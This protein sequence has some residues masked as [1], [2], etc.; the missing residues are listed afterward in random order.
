MNYKSDIINGFNKPSWILHPFK[1]LKYN[2]IIKDISIVADIIHK[3]N[4]ELAY[5]IS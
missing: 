1:R 3:Y 4:S 2:R 5:M